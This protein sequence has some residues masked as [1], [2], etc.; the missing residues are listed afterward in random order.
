V[1]AW[2]DED[3]IQSTWASRT[4][5][6]PQRPLKGPGRACEGALG[7]C[8][9]LL[10]SAPIMPAMAQT[11]YPMSVSRFS[12]LSANRAGDAN[13][14]AVGRSVT[15]IIP[16]DRHDEEPM[17]LERVRRDERIDHY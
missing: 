6:P 16:T 8:F 9:V 14:E 12:R 15:I 5:T 1:N 4:H 10:Y 17:I 7:S 11:S 13:E 3:T 2:L